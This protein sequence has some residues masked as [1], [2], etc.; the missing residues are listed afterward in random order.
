VVHGDQLGEG[1]DAQ[2][3]GPCVDLVTDPEVGDGGTDADDD[4]GH[5]VA[6]DERR[7]V[8]DQLFE[9]PVADHLVERVDAR[10]AD[11]DQ[12]LVAADLGVGDLGGPQGVLAV[13]VD[14]VGLHRRNSN[15]SATNAS[16]NWKMP[17]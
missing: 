17:P 4:P 8:L 14:D 15:A 16:W 9:L 10:G 1:P 11:A 6:Q 3:A 13:L 5:V 12:H 2:V 7:L